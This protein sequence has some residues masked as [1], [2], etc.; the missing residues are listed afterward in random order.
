MSEPKDATLIAALESR[1]G[2]AVHTPG[3]EGYD[4]C[5]EGMQRLDEHRPQAVVEAADA[6]D[7]RVAVEAA[8]RHRV[9]VAAQATGHGRGSGLESGILLSTG[10]LTGVRVD[11]ERRTAWVPAGTRWQEVLDAADPHGL[12]PLSGSSPQVGA[13]S[14]T[15]GGG[16]GLLARRH[17]FAADHVRRVDLATADGRARQVTAESDPELFWAVRGAGTSLGV[18]TGMEIDLFPVPR[19][20]GGSLFLD[21][22][23]A[24]GVLEAWR[25]WTATVPEEL[26]SGV[27]LLTWPDMEGVPEAMRGRTILQVAVAYAGEIEKGPAWVEPL[28]A[29]APVLLDT[30]GEWAFRDSGAIF[31]EH[32]DPAGFAGHSMLLDELPT[33]ASTELVRRVAGPPPFFTVV[34]VRHL[35]GALARAPQIPS[36]VGHR[37]AGYAL[38]VLTFTGPQ[39]PED[40][41]AM[42]DFR[43]EAAALFAGTTIGRSATLTFGPQSPAEVREMFTPEDHRRLVS[44]AARLDPQGVL[45]SHRPLA[46]GTAPAVRLMSG[47]RE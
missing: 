46:P 45:H 28:R 31:D 19:L 39:E 29:A 43:H 27:S 4:R 30:M 7:V 36:A 22:T 26:T 32:H 37:Q 12:A 1:I 13:V 42:R 21:A 15:L 41:E 47:R 2:G 25:R 44:L 38:G 8:A 3:T 24:P 20:Y 10:R 18:V 11:P 16:V 9:P 23:H 17:G 6:E 33:A 34:W 35:G 40:T 5:R 14:Y